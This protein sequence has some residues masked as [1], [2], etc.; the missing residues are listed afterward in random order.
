MG[1][2]KSFIELTKPRLSAMAVFSGSAGYVMARDPNMSFSMQNY[3]G[4]LWLTLGLSF[5]GAASNIVN[6]AV[7]HKLDKK[8]DRTA[9]RPIP[10]GRVQ[11]GEAL[12]FGHICLAI[13]LYILFHF[14]RPEVGYLALFTYVTYVFMYTPMKT[15]TA[16]NTIAG[17]FPGAFPILTGWVANSNNDFHTLPQ[18]E[19]WGFFPFAIV[20]VWQ[21]PHFFS[22]AWIYKEDYQRAGY[23]MMSLYDET[24][25]QAVILI[26]VGTLGLMA[27]SLMP[28]MYK[29][30]N[31]WYFLSACILNAGFL[32]S[33][34]LLLINRERFMK[35]YFYASI[36]YLPL[37]VLA[38]IFFPL[39]TTP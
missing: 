11:M 27:V 31:G 13:G 16:L 39:T 15:K 17:A 28:Y 3:L 33:S 38:L 8:M 30:S 29:M 36:I 20:F 1:R 2:V 14:F 21:L 22:I 19:W 6:Q 10:S 34:V 18:T 7:E 4:L 12:F 24:G 25:K 32:C 5:V 23:K 9:D 26:F 37:I 35:Q